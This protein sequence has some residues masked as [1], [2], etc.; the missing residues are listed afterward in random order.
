MTKP[1]CYRGDVT[2]QGREAA[3]YSPAKGKW[4]CPQNFPTARTPAIRHPGLSPARQ[5]RD[6]AGA[7]H[8]RG[9]PRGHTT[10]LSSRAC[11]PSHPGPLQTISSKGP[12]PGAP[13]QLSRIPAAAVSLG[14]PGATSDLFFHKPP[15]QVVSLRSWERVCELWEM[16]G[17]FSENIVHFRGVWGK[18][19]Q[20]SK[21][22][23]V[24]KETFFGQ[25]STAL[26]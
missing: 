24:D 15:Q 23:I 17:K 5:C 21:R 1:G 10:G 9:R 3:L 8:P 18:S 11:V 16:S 26:L 19:D 6:P 22:L 13:P 20:P 2:A 25:P 7:P 12:R 4:G 14:A